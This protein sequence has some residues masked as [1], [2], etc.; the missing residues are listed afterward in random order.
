[1]NTNTINTI[2]F[3]P[4]SFIANHYL[5]RVRSEA[6]KAYRKAGLSFFKR[7]DVKYFDEAHKEML[8]DMLMTANTEFNA[9]LAAK[10][11]DRT[12]AR[13]AAKLERET[14][15]AAAKAAKDEIVNKKKALEAELKAMRLAEKEARAAA[16]AAREAAKAERDAA[17]K[18]S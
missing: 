4:F 10:S 3:V 15:R 17:K 5:P 11:T 6:E 7:G 18:A 9:K 2:T 14:A 12:I 1:M 16:K 13:A 8:V